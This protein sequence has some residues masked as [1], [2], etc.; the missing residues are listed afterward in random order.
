MRP[1]ALVRPARRGEPQALGRLRFRPLGIDAAADHLV[2]V[3]AGSHL[4]RSEGLGAQTRLSV[5]HQGWSLIATLV[6]VHGDLLAIDEVSLSRSA[7]ETLGVLPGETLTFAHVPVLESEALIRGK[8]RGR[9]LD[10]PAADAIVGDAVSGRLSQLHL[11][12]FITACAG[13]RLDLDE[14]VA[15]THAMLRGGV[16]LA[17]GRSPV[18]DKHCVGGLAGNRTTP[19]VV[20]IA[21]ALG[22]TMP[23][24]SSRAITSAAGTADTMEVLAPVTLDLAAMRRVVEETGG[25]IVWGGT[26]RLSPADDVLIRVS[27]PLGL[28]SEGQLVASVMSK[29]VAAGSQRV[30]VDLP[31]G[32][33]AKVRD[34]ESAEA[35]GARLVGVGEAFGLEVRTIFT[36]GSCPVGRGIGPALEARDVLQVLQGAA[37]APAD[38]ADRAAMLAGAVLELGGVAASGHGEALARAALADGRAWRQFQRICIAQGGLRQVPRAPLVTEL[39]AERA[40]I[41]RSI[42]NRAVALLAKLA[43]APMAKSAGLDLLVGVGQRV[44]R[45]Q[46]LFAL[47]AEAPGELAYALEHARHGVTAVAVDG[48]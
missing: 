46:P 23:K 29:K 21:T 44:E 47:H 42:D 37:Q 9:R 1:G 36:D 32:A 24:T 18:V 25:C 33:A 27:R 20:A 19:I 7:Q 22:L 17:W 43:G 16:R 2:F 39:H 26:A 5:R 14:T 6:I 4:C 3:N 34:L 13:G 31:V 45:G 8:I 10:G 12:A 38:L 30:L 40:G 48:D 11:A 15:L 28:D 35:L 41:V